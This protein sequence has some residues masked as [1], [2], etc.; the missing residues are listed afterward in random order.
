[1]KNNTIWLPFTQM[2]T[3]HSLPKAVSAKG[4]RI[5]LKNGQ[6]IIDAI[7][8][9]WVITLGHCEPSI[10]KAVQKQAETM[11]QVLFA[12]FFTPTSY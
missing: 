4:S 2:K 6:S 10:V 9:W 12:N 1:M 7:S 8:S 5:Y 3:V 11:D